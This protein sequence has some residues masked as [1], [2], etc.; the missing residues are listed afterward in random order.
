MAREK[1]KAAFAYLRTSS[2]ANVGVD[3]DSA[4]RASGR[5]LPRLRDGSGG[6]ADGQAPPPRQPDQR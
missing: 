2:T 4:K 5:P 1:P 6:R 3:K